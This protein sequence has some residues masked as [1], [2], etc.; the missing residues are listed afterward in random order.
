MEVHMVSSSTA[1]PSRVKPIYHPVYRQM[2][3]RLVA[4][5]KRRGLTQEQVAK[6]VGVRRQWVSKIETYEVSIDVISL[7]HLCHLYRIRPAELA[8]WMGRRLPHAG[9]FFLLLNRHV[10]DWP[11]FQTCSIVYARRARSMDY[12]IRGIH[13]TIFD[14]TR[15]A[16]A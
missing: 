12:R 3:Q 4:T 2:I 9:A 7:L 16:W 6:V 15:P 13:P 14:L 8:G 11:G 5:R 10:G 1:R